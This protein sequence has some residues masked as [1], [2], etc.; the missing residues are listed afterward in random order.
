[1][2]VTNVCGKYLASSAVHQPE[3]HLK[4][5]PF[6]SERKHMATHPSIQ[7]YTHLVKLHHTARMNAMIY[8]LRLL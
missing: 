5:M 7:F 1:M 6:M 4:L 2:Q 8:K 3:F